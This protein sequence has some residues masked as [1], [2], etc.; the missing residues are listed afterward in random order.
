M[1]H[2]LLSI[3]GGGVRGVVALEVLARIEQLLRDETGDADLVLGDWFDYVGGTSTG[4]I[5]AGGVALGLP[6][7]RIQRLYHENMRSIFTRAGLLGLVRARYD[8]VGIETVLRREFGEDRTLGSA[9]LR[10]LLLLGLRNTST[11]S[12]WPVSSNPAGRY[13]QGERSNLELPLWQLVRAS[14]A[15]PTFFVP[16]EVDVGGQTFVFS[17]GAVTTLNNPA[18]QLVLMATLPAYRL[19]WPTGRDELL[20]VSVGTGTSEQVQVDLRA[21]DLNLLDYATAVPEALIH[22]AAVQNDYLCRVLGECRSG[23]VLDTELGD[24]VGGAGLLP[25]PLFSYVRYDAE[26]H[27]ASLASLG[28]THL[29]AEHLDR[30]DGVDYLDEMR[31]FGRAVARSVDRTH[32]VGFLGRG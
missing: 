17:D 8:E 4:A 15:A 32:F 13:N 26:T 5:I 24:L 20:L 12:P 29:S 7:S 22:S 9:D 11:G 10:C 6:V 28:V 3:D 2:R 23:P 19:N 1:S 27:P 18:L 21:D 31:E 14:A 25:E 30:I 16:E